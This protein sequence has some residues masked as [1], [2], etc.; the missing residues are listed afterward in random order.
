M[1]KDFKFLRE[2]EKPHSSPIKDAVVN[3]INICNRTDMRYENYQHYFI[4]GNNYLKLKVSE[5]RNYRNPVFSYFIIRYKIGESTCNMDNV[6]NFQQLRL[7]TEEY[8]R[9]IHETL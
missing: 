2:N 9:L 5:I 6:M 4:H 8:Y 3:A 7:E 1:I